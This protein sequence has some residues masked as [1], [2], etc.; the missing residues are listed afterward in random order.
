MANGI[1]VDGTELY[2]DWLTN[3]FRFTFIR[4]GL[5]SLPSYR[6]EDDVIPQAAGRDPG[7]WTPDV[8]EVVLHGLV[9]GT[10]ASAQAVRESFRTRTDILLGLMDVTTLVDIVA[11][12]PNFGLAAGEVATLPDCRPLAIEGED[13]S[14]HWYEGWEISLRFECI[15]SPPD[16]QIGS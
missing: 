5:Q 1:K 8:R 11:Y 12:P 2:A 10:G 16:W 4:G 3:G 15:A 13:A 9:A 14:L 6:G 7:L